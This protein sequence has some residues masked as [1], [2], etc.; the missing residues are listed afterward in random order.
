MAEET[1]EAAGEVIE[2]LPHAIAG[3]R[4]DGRIGM[5]NGL[6]RTMLAER[7]VRLDRDS[8]YP[9]CLSAFLTAA[10][11]AAAE[12]D[13]FLQA[14]RHAH[15]EGES[16]SYSIRRRGE[17]SI[18]FDAVPRSDG[19]L[20]LS[21]E[22][23]SAFERRDAMLVEA[24]LMARSGAWQHDRRTGQL[25]FSEGAWAVFGPGSRERIGTLAAWVEQVHPE[26]RGRMMAAVETAERT[27]QPYT[28]D[29]RLYRTDGQLIDIS[30]QGRVVLD[31]AQPPRWSRGTFRDITPI[32]EAQRAVERSE[33]KFRA[34]VDNNPDVIAI[35]DREGRLDFVS[36]AGER[37]L[38]HEGPEV[39]GH[40]WAEFVHPDDLGKAA[41]TLQRLIGRQ[42][43]KETTELRL[44]HKDG[45]WL[46]MEIVGSNF[47]D[48]SGVQGIVFTAH[49]MTDRRETENRLRQA[50][51]MEA[52]GQLT[53]GI[54]HDFN[55]L[56]AVI[57]GNL[58]LIGEGLDSLGGPQ[59][60]PLLRM[61]GAALRA[62]DRG[63]TLTRSLLAFSRQQT[64]RPSAV[65]LNGLVDEMHELLRRTMSG[66]VGLEVQPC[67]DLWL[68]EVDSGLMQN[69]LLN[70]VLNARDAMPDG[71][72]LTIATGNAVLDAPQADA[73]DEVPPGEYVLLAVSD[74]GFG[75]DAETLARAFD[76]F[77]TTKGV[78]QGTGLGLSMVYGFAK[79]SDGHARI[80]SAP[81]AGT[82][83]RIYLPRIA[84]AA[85]TA[86]RDPAAQDPAARDRAVQDPAP[87]DPP[88][89]DPL[90]LPHESPGTERIL[91][92]EDDP[93]VRNL[94]RA[95]LRSL[96]Y[97]THAVSGPEEA[98]RHLNVAPDL[99][100]LLTDINLSDS[101]N[102]AELAARA[103]ALLPRLRVV[104]MSG[105]DDGVLQQQGVG[106]RQARLLRKPFRKTELAAAIRETLDREA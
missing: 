24:E 2:L 71:G 77:F 65:D 97:L 5:A 74:T 30:A 45:R 105:H 29:Y 63:A 26:D 51:K 46:T 31:G 38:G 79:Q 13:A 59:A 55:N 52:V 73:A 99:D 61:C 14:R 89:P 103:V 7:G 90:P 53:G 75:M 20:L 56:L 23:Q 67:P 27:S 60:A 42:K 4:P 44:R 70:L 39:F 28:C 41:E 81:G 8:R 106:Q 12:Q 15:R 96:G 58:E 100:L 80:Q 95:T 36:P 6:F 101:M 18:R 22:D 19:S 9:D 83:V 1:G 3:V 16:D 68:C 92:V 94:A 72:T 49:D 104:F 69:A 11:L 62:S 50:Q 48:T 66:T 21:T 10:G 87:R 78:G 84:G 37:I 32:R 25:Y 88:R 85:V 57:S 43:G 86:S 40:P 64:L 82:T 98:L 17:W 76:P 33:A 35:I 54:A 93:D 91:V 34:I 102:G 47:L